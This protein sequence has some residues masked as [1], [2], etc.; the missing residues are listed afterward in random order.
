MPICKNIQWEQN[1]HGQWK[2]IFTFEYFE[3]SHT[4]LDIPI[5][6]LNVRTNINTRHFILARSV[7]NRFRMHRTENLLELKLCIQYKAFTLYEEYITSL[8]LT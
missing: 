4:N 5:F 6:L 2:D 7:Y 8:I 1:L 3:T